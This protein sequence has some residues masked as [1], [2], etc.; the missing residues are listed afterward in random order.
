M[1]T[2]TDATGELFPDGPPSSVLGPRL[3][4][5]LD[6]APPTLDDLGLT[7]AKD[8][9]FG[10]QQLRSRA[11]WHEMVAAMKRSAVADWVP[12]I[13]GIFGVIGEQVLLAI[14]AETEKTITA[15]YL[16]QLDPAQ[17]ASVA[18]TARALRFFAEGQ[19]N[20]LTIALHGL[21]NLTLRTLALD[22]AFQ[23]TDV[24]AARV[25]AADFVPGSDA[26]GAWCSVTTDTRDALLTAAAGYAA[27][28]LPLAQQ[29]A[30]IVDDPALAGLVAFRNVHYHRW[31]G[32]SPGVT[33][34]DLSA[35]TARQRLERGES[36]GLN[37]RLLPTYTAGQ[38]ALDDLVATSR[39]ALDALVA[40]MP[41]Y[42]EAWWTAFRDALGY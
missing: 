23:L 39:A 34:I 25:T 22:R 20:A 33:G 14:E 3:A 35:P 1:P 37:R 6:A 15:G 12:E 42:Q 41:D 29:F 18:H 19:A 5:H 27:P 16:T 40:R 11:R 21:A 10:W 30:G 38:Q 7:A 8:A 24:K 26:R 13:H 36:V 32:E 31:R 17:Q 4:V 2:G 9:G 28:M